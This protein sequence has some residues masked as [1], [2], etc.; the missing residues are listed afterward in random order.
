M[1]RPRRGRTRERSAD[2]FGDDLGGANVV[3]FFLIASGA[4]VVSVTSISAVVV[5]VAS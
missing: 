5:V 1:R 4:I 3:V 2:G